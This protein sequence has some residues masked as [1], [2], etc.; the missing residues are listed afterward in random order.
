MGTMRRA[1]RSARAVAHGPEILG[2]LKSES[3]R[4]LLRLTADSGAPPVAAISADII[5]LIGLEDAKLAP[6]K[7]FVGVCVRAILEE[8]GYQPAARGVRL[9]KDPLFRTGTTY[10][11][12]AAR[13]GP[14]NLLERFIRALTPEE[15][16]VAAELVSRA[17]RQ[18]ASS[19]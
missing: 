5:Q 10:E 16:T 4:E 9:S 6:V 18:D 14:L 17:R 3:S 13:T 19:R 11:R 1:T 15:L 2:F 7:Q 8:A 12:Q